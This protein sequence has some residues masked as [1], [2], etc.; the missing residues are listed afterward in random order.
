MTEK[1]NPWTTC[2]VLT[3]KP[4][5]LSD[6]GWWATIKWSWG[7]F[8]DPEMVEGEIRTRYPTGLRRAIDQVMDMANQFGVVTPPGVGMAL[9][10]EGD[11]ENPE[12]AFPKGW[13]NKVRREAER[14]GWDSYRAKKEEA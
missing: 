13:R 3:W 9:Y 10:V 6:G 8:C 7:K 1:K 12:F 4:R 2:V 14:R 5:T 11:G